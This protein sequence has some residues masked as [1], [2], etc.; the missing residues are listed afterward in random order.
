LSIAVLAGSR[1]AFAVRFS[2]LQHWLR[3]ARRCCSWRSLLVCADV[4]PA[5]QSCAARARGVR[6]ALVLAKLPAAPDWALCAF[7]FG[8]GLARRAPGLVGSGVGLD[9]R[10][11]CA[12]CQRALRR[13]RELSSVAAGA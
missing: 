3:A 6:R 12:P 7:A 9:A 13:G 10:G 5:G 8:I 11:G 1:T 4:A 2:Y